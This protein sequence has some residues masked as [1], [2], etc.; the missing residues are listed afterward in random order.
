MARWLVISDNHGDRAILET[1]KHQFH[2]DAVFHCG[3]SEL[4]VDDP[5]FT[6]VAAVRG[7]MDSDDRFPLVLTPE[8]NGCRVLL[9]HG[10]R[11]AVNW[12]LTKLAL[13]AQSVGAQAAF[14]GHTH[15]LAVEMVAGCL[16]LNPGSISQPRGE[17]RQLGGTCAV[18]TV[19]PDQWQVQYYTR[20]AHPVTKLH[21]TFDRQ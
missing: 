10:H 8:V 18:V 13:H 7:N 20:D 3:D 17:F 19:T 16:F 11:D 5:W 4:A 15:E 21:F 2:A 1:L 14:Y 9:A 12:D 6:G